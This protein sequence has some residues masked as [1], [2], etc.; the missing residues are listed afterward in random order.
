VRI[1]AGEFK[2]RVLERVSDPGVRP[3]SDKVREAWF[4][5][6]GERVRAAAVVDLFAGSG[7]LGLEAL[8][9]G[10]RHALFVERSQ[11]A[12]ATL[13]A[14]IDL[15]EVAERARIRR[16]DALRYAAGLEERAFD[17][18]FADPPYA[19]DRAARLVTIFRKRPFAEILGVEHAA[20]LELSGDERR[21]YG[22]IALTFCYAP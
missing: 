17:L 16:T 8:S 22:T 4:D 3:T 10:A 13:G 18:A 1:I 21:T 15:L 2:G 7:A 20:S 19:G 5:I 14:N 11:R 6:L 12:L 9:R